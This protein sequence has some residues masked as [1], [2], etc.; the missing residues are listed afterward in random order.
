MAPNLL[1]IIFVFFLL[2]G[3]I[4]KTFPNC[5]NL[6]QEIIFN[7]GILHIKS[8]LLEKDLKVED[9]SRLAGPYMPDSWSSD[10]DK[11]CVATY[12]M[13]IIKKLMMFC[14]YKRQLSGFKAS[15]FS[16]WLST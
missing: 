8:H 12:K 4:G 3:A 9:L 14:L 6:D 15:L 7:E 2:R 10:D 13:K 1:T 11:K 16:S 5:E